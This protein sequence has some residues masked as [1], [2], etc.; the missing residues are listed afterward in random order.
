MKQWPLRAYVLAVK[1]VLRSAL[2]AG[3]GALVCS[4]PAWGQASYSVVGNITMFDAVDG[5][6]GGG[7]PS[8]GVLIK[9]SAGLPGN[10][11]GSSSGW[12]WIPASSS[13]MTAY[14]IGLWLTGTAGSVSVTVYT[15]GLASNGF[16][17]VVQVQPSS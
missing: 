11:S 2:V 6:A 7:A 1:H 14:V 3:M 13:A 9:V 12:M 10:C 5:T 4:S 17:Q 16:C 15:V 8:N